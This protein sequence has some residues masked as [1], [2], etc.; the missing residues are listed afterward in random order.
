MAT[1][2]RNTTLRVMRDDVL[3]L[4]GGKFLPKGDYP[5][6]V[7]MIQVAMRGQT[8]NHLGRVMLA[9]TEAQ[10]AAALGMSPDPRKMGMEIDVSH[11]YKSGAIEEV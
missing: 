4:G 5:G 7:S 9:L 3:D 10:I 11:A 2:K 1:T 6:M 8:V